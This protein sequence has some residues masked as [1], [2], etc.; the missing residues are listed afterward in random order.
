[1]KKNLIFDVGG[2]LIGYRWKEMLMD[3]FGL[4]DEKAEEM[5]R[6]IFDDP[7]W[8]DFDRGLVD[9]DALV[10]HYCS[11]YPKDEHDIKRM[12]YDNDKMATEREAVW[13]MI[14]E[15]KDRGYSIYI[16]S[17]YSE[18]LF[19]KHTG[20]MPFRRFLDGGIVSYEAGAVKPEPAIYKMLLDKYDL[21]PSTCIFFD[22]I[23]KNVEAARTLGIESHLVTSE[24]DLLDKLGCLER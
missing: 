17:N 7:L 18:Y 13:E 10:E 6:K 20:N 4:S 12:F 14:A 16:L 22:D 2:V 19:K 21:D 1:M 24:E 23:E 11:L 3:D 15:L 9:I 5:G 8:P